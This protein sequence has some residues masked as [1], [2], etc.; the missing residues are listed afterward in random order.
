MATCRLRK[1]NLLIV[2]SDSM[3]GRAMG[4]IGHPAA[5][6]PH[7]DRLAERGTR[8]SQAYC[9]SPQCCPARAS[10]WSGRYV[11]QVQ[12]WLEKKAEPT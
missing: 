1:P 3:D 11:H 5:H 8:F 9:N 10:T 12:A 4:C 2:Q 7:L 6:T